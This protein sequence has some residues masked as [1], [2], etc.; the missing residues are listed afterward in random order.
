MRITALMIAGIAVALALVAGCTG[1]SIQW[2]YQE[3]NGRTVEVPAGTEIIVSLPENPTTGYTWE[4][5]SGGL[6]ATG[7]EYYPDKV[8]E[9]TVG[10]GGTH[11]WKYKAE[12]A[13]T[14]TIEGIY[15]RAWEETATDDERWQATIIVK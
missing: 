7:D 13:G 4:M 1:T 11:E 8:P 6:A 14:Y 5:N 9:G 2:L 12:K 3:D 15:K 10:S